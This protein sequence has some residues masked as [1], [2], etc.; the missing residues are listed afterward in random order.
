MTSF[1]LKTVHNI[2][3]FDV[4]EAVIQIVDFVNFDIALTLENRRKKVKLNKYKISLV[5]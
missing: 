1:Y 3:I 2:M 5:N 4:Q